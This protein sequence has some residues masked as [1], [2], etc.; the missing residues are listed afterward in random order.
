MKQLL[1]VFSAVLM[2]IGCQNKSVK[3]WETLKFIHEKP[4]LTHLNL[5]DTAHD[6][7]DAMAFESVLKDTTADLVQNLVDRSIVFD[8]DIG[9]MHDKMDEFNK[10][11]KEA[12]LAIQSINATL[13][14]LKKKEA[15]ENKK[16]QSK[17]KSPRV[18]MR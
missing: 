12:E 15:E 5:G 11:I 9:L 4:A 14:N 1:I 16:I 7:G 6:H 17:M 3:K 8:N 18:R 13:P 2:M 10:E